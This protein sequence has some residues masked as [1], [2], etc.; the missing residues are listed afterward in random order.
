MNPKYPSTTK[1]MN[2]N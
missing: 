2:P 1:K